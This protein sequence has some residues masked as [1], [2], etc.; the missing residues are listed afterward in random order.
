MLI[1]SFAPVRGALLAWVFLGQTLPANSTIGIA[2]VM[3][4]IIWVVAERGKPGAVGLKL[5]LRRGVVAA[6]L[7][8]LAQATAF[9]FASKGVSG[10]FPP[11]SAALIRITAG[12]IALWVLI[13]FQGRIRSTAAV[14][15]NDRVLFLQLAGAALSGPVIASSFLLLSLQF[16]PVGVATTLS[17]TTSI[18]LI[19]V[20]YF[21]FKERITL[22]AVVGTIITVIGIAILFT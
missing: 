6:C 3:F 8:T 4:G 22:R 20:G 18:V 15:K 21:V 2:V 9:V 17:H 11:L 1:A 13:A 7:G 19:P 16:I 14:F 10:G 5:D 12:M